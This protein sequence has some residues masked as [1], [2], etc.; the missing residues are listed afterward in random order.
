[1]FSASGCS[2]RSSMCVE[3]SGSP[4][5]RTWPPPAPAAPDRAAGPAEELLGAM[6]G[7]DEDRH[8]VRRGEVPHVV[9]AGDG[10]GDRGGV[11][12]V[13][14]RLS[15]EELRPAVRELDDDGSIRR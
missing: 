15:G 11:L 8:A 13:V 3:K 12:A 1:M 14:E 7:V 5:S 9:R 4:R 6:V 10:A 2:L